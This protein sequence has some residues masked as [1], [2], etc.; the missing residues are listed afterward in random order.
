[1]ANRENY[2]E[3]VIDKKVLLSSSS[4]YHTTDS[5]ENILSILKKGFRPFYSLEQSYIRKNGGVASINVGV[6]MICMSDL[7]LT[8]LKDNLEAYGGFAIGMSYEWATKNGFTPVRYIDVTSDE[9][10]NS[11]APIAH[12]QKIQKEIKV[13]DLVLKFP[14][15]AEYLPQMQDDAIRRI[16]LMKPYIADLYRDS[17]EEVYKDYNF[18]N[19]REWRYVP[20]ISIEDDFEP[21]LISEKYTDYLKQRDYNE[22]NLM[23][24]ESLFLEFDL[25]K[26][27]NYIIV[28]EE[29]DIDKLFLKLG[30]GNFE[31][32]LRG[33][34]LVT[35]KVLKDF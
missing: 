20:P 2:K 5:L 15:L 12:Q 25:E 4:F 28:K 6:P 8:L 3:K 33:K 14:S 16:Q 17:K 1:M 18:Y 31:R 23:K 19:E 27:L 9:Y 7:P 10:Q 21:I 35:E 13:E 11:F 32:V 22:K 24:K 30:K 26:D 34:L 29:K